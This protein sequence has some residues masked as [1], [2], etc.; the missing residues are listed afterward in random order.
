LVRAIPILAVAMIA[1]R[2]IAVAIHVPIEAPWPRGNFARAAV[3]H[4]L[5][6]LPGQ[7]LVIVRYAPGHDVNMEWVYN[8]ADI[9]DSKVV[10]AREMGSEQNRVLS[11]YFQNRTAWL[12]NAD[13]HPVHLE[14]S[15]DR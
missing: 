13:T 5:S 11:A 8:A 4:E 10:W 1:I 15:L 6:Q 7:Q 3:N 9:D 14:P 2:V 12:L